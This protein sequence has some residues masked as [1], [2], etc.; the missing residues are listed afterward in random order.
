MYFEIDHLTSYRYSVP[1]R[2]GEHL[3][4]FHP[5][6]TP[7][8][9]VVAFD[10]SI[11]PCPSFRQVKVDAWGN[12]A[13]QVFFQ[14]ETTH[15][16]IRANLR[17]ETRNPLAPSWASLPM[18]I[19]YGP[20]REPLA[21]YLALIEE[22]AKLQGFIA[23]LLTRGSGMDFLQAL[24]AAVHRFYQQ[25]IRVDGPPRGPAETLA[26]GEGVCR[27]LSVL[28]IAACRQVGVAARFASGY[29]Q[30][31]GQRLQRHL[32]AW[33][34]VFLP[35]HGWYGVDPTHNAPAGEDHVLVAA[36]PDAASVTPVEGGYQFDGPLLDSTLQTEIIISTR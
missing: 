9:R 31:S 30:E 17:L 13:E 26:L 6:A 1:V 28:F 4:R 14:G 15:L 10:L 18:P 19:D 16:E 5:P 8:Q 34:E 35:G 29:Q 22:P 20:D 2:L 23:P 12:P 36:A 33:P 3:V 11:S 21:P 27:D 7:S 32:H 24:S 25:G